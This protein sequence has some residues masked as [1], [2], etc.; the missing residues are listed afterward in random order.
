MNIFTL[1]RTSL[2]IVVLA[3]SSAILAADY[4]PDTMTVPAS[5]LL[6]ADQLKGEHYSVA[7][8]VLVSGYMNHYTVNSDYGQFTAVGNRKM[9]KLLHEI[10]AIS[11]A[12]RDD[13]DQCGYRC[14]DWRS[15]R[16]RGFPGR[17]C[18]R[19]GGVDQQPGGRGI[20]P[21]QAY[22]EDCET[23]Q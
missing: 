9:K 23:G 21:L 19:S 6:D 16:Y 2:L 12:E 5:S 13:L 11:Q 14:C 1:I 18:D 20:P 22:V 4:E 7:N 17:T 8:D 3:V 15:S 10:D